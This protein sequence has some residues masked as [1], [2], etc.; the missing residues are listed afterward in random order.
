MR[1]SFDKSP[2]SNDLLS[3]GCLIQLSMARFVVKSPTNELAAHRPSADSLVGKGESLPVTRLVEFDAD[4]NS[5]KL[6][7][8]LA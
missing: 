5:S 4:C 1:H 7:S 8:A 3:R 6:V 2:G